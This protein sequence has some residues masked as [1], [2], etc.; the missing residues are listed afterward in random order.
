[1]LM[2]PTF[3][4]RKPLTQ[5]GGSQPE[6]CCALLDVVEDGHSQCHVPAKCMMEYLATYINLSKVKVKLSINIPYM[7]HIG[8]DLFV[9]ITG[10]HHFEISFFPGAF[11]LRQSGRRI[12]SHVSRIYQGMQDVYL[13][14]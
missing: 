13:Q 7:E 3:I 10:S 1:M 5:M 11:D 6:A 4:A 12:V 8:K 2:T 14:L 9:N